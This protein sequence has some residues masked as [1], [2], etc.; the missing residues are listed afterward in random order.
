MVAAKGNRGKNVFFI[1]GNYDADWNLAIIGA[2]GG[3]EGAAA[4]VEADFSAKVAAERG[5]ERGALELRGV[6]GGW[7]DVLQHRAENIFEDASVG[8]KGIATCPTSTMS[9]VVE[10][11]SLPQGIQGFTGKACDYRQ[12]RVR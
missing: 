10:K 6:S 2:V 9:Y 7:G 1:A 12:D 8:R 11:K 5:F 3:V 4:R